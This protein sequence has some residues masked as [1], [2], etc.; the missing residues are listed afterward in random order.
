MQAVKTVGV[1]RRERRWSL[2]PRR[3]AQSWEIYAS[4]IF[5]LFYLAGAPPGSAASIALSAFAV[6]TFLV[7]YFLAYWLTPVAA[8]APIG[9]VAI[10][11]ALLTPDHPGASVFLCYAASLACYLF[12]WRYAIVMAATVLGAF[13]LIAGSTGYPESY[14]AINSL[15]IVAVAAIYVQARRSAVI[16]ER[17]RL[18]EAELASIHRASERRRIAHDLHDQLGQ[19]LV[20]IALKADL[21]RKQAGAGIA[22]AEQQLLEIGDAARET[23]NSVRRVVS[24]YSARPL[25]E[26]LR[27]AEEVLR[28]AGVEPSIDAQIPQTMTEHQECFTGLILREAA[29]NVARH[30]RACACSIRVG[31]EA[32]ELVLEV[33]D[34]GRGALRYDG[35]GTDGMRE[36]A[37]QIGGRLE[38]LRENGTRVILRAPLGSDA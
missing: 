12:P 18:R 4:L 34:N 28:L 26:E 23:L 15:V 9:G 35:F 25:M 10:L 11:G 2:L 32:G 17:L 16:T 20:L 5:L 14:L 27:H 1:G 3:H 8:A 6:A 38:L 29:T 24:G 22:G 13:L 21:G 30:A 36:R 31:A 19:H 37:V 7:L 33:V